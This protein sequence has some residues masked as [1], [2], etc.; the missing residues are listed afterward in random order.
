MK[1]KHL[2]A[3]KA[4]S[5][6]MTL[7]M[8]IF[9]CPPYVIVNA[10]NKMQTT[11][12]EYPVFPGEEQWEELT[13]E[14]R[15]EIFTI[16]PE[17]AKRMTTQALLLSVLEN[18]LSCCI[19]GLDSVTEGIETYRNIFPFFNE[20]LNRNDIIFELNRYIDSFNT[21]V[22]EPEDTEMLPYYIGCR[23]RQYLQSNGTAS[24]TYFI[25]PNTGF[26]GLY[27][28]TPNHTNV[29]VYW[30]TTYADHGTTESESIA[31]TTQMANFYSA[32]IIKPAS[33]KYNCHTYAWYSTTAQAYW[34]EDPSAYMT[35]GSYASISSIVAG[36]K[37]T[38]KYQSYLCHSGIVSS[39]SP[40]GTVYVNSKWG[41]MGVL[42]HTLTG[43][44]YYSL[45]GATNIDFWYKAV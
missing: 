43:N 36:R 39:I 20:L 8:F 24:P 30:N 38:Y 28:Q 4:L 1:K 33:S 42:Q 5:I 45:Y 9:I 14:E 19:Y 27:V 21:S 29:L 17:T 12:Y 11:P 37:V 32:T 7:I 18:P 41:C 35:D 16:D 26:L 25:D 23:I 2:N 34:M 31:S 22:L 44:L 10:R 13:V 3:K 6:I 15:T 40:T